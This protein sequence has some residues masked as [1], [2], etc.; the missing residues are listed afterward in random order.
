MDIHHVWVVY[1]PLYEKVVCVHADEN[2]I[3][4]NCEELGKSRNGTYYLEVKKFK[5]QSDI[6]TPTLSKLTDFSKVSSLRS[7]YFIPIRED[8]CDFL[9]DE[10]SELSYWSSYDL[11]WV[12]IKLDKAYWDIIGKASDAL[13]EEDVCREIVDTTL[14]GYFKRYDT[15]L[16]LSG[17]EGCET[18]VESLR[19]YINILQKSDDYLILE[20]YA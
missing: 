1:D 10:N 2:T 16:D 18:A 11:E 14:N 5:V 9:I 15:F 19:S 4:D 8:A 17:M 3:C 12:D 13:K 7:F 6:P 20:K